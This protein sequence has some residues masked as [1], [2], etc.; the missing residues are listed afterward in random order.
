MSVDRRPL[1]DERVD[2]LLGVALQVA[3][4]MRDDLDAAHRVVRWLDR[5]DLE[6][7]ACILA[8]LVPVEV[9]VASLAWWRFPLSR[10]SGGQPCGTWAA[11]TRHRAKGEPLDV[12]CLAAAKAYQQGCQARRRGAA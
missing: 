5:T 10:E 3:A 8:A 9:P 11:A 1:S 2:Q 12:L 6:A 7:V 4:D